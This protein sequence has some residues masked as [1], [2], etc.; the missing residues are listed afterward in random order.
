[1][2]PVLDPLIEL[3]RDSLGHLTPEQCL[4]GEHGLARRLHRSHPPGYSRLL[5]VAMAGLPAVVG[6]VLLLKQGLRSDPLLYR[7]ENGVVGPA[8]DLRAT[9]TAAPLLRFSDGTEVRLAEGAQ[10]RIRFVTANGAGLAIDRGRLHAEVVHTSKS[11]WRFDA[12]PFTVHVTGTSFGL[13]WQPDQDR[14]DLRLEQGNVTVTGPVAN[15]PIPVRSGQWLTIRTRSNV[16][17]IRD[18]MAI[19][20][21]AFAEP[22]AG[23]STE[24]PREQ[25]SSDS[26]SPSMPQATV[27]NRARNIAD[28]PRNWAS[29]LAEGHLDSIVQDAQNRGL[30]DCLAKVGSN[31]LSALADA[32]RYTR[33]SEIARKALLAQRQRFAGSR[34][35]IEAA[36]AGEVGGDRQK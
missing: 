11:E 5:L 9:G 23:S 15:D 1:M 21:T 29:D 17:M 22:L 4:R 6:L 28:P 25:G 32:A 8:Q 20:E 33:R 27:D 18:L 12:G 36:F 31:E 34:R 19:E 14:F 35:A 30:D 2:D 3:A 16:V 24:S 26:S 10:A 7:V 13:E